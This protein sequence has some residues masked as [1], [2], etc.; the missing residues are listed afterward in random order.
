MGMVRSAVVVVMM[1]VDRCRRGR[2]VPMPR[3]QEVVEFMEH[4]SD[5]QAGQTRE[6]HG[7]QTDGEAL[8]FPGT[9]H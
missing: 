5:R 8:S 6:E 4:R 2:I 9:A 7:Q 3:H 1:A